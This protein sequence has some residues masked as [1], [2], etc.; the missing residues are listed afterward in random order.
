MT[1]NAAH[2]RIRTLVQMSYIAKTRLTLEALS[3][4]ESIFEQFPNFSRDYFQHHQ[5][6]QRALL[7]RTD[8]YMCYF[9][10]HENITGYDRDSAEVCPYPDGGDWIENVS[11]NHSNQRNWTGMPR[12]ITSGSW[13]CTGQVVNSALTLTFLPYLFAHTCMQS[14]QRE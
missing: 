1:N 8:T 14:S 10:D 11:R 4:W 12:S 7:S 3:E 13:T 2:G 9:Y 5:Q 6:L